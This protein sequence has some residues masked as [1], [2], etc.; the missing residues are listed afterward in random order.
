MNT[1]KPIKYT[2]LPL[3]YSCSGASSAA[4]MANHIAVKLDRAEVAEMSCIAGVGG[5]VKP[6]V[7]SAKSGRRIV[8]VDGCPLKCAA[9]ILQ[10]HGITANHHYDLSKMGVEKKMHEDFD[11]DDAD[12]ILERVKADLARDVKEGV[13]APQA[14]PAETRTQNGGESGTSESTND[15][16]EPGPELASSPCS[17]REYKDW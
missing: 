3:V 14:L 12:G 9:H 8:A 6:L 17:L 15:P 2:D 5:D 10:R 1:N 7:R 16:G 13:D 4:Q 11:P